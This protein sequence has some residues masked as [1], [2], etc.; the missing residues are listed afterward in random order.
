[1]VRSIV[2]AS[3]NSCIDLKAD[4]KVLDVPRH[5][6]KKT[7][8]YSSSGPTSLQHRNTISTTVHGQSMISH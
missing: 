7:N 3:I 5:K 4:L 6:R 1:M 8:V 2:T